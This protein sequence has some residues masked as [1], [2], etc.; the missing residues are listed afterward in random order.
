MFVH[1]LSRLVGKNEV[2]EIENGG[3]LTYVLN[4]LMPTPDRTSEDQFH[5]CVLFSIA[6]KHPVPVVNSI[7]INTTGTSSN[8]LLSHQSM[9]HCRARQISPPCPAVL[10]SCYCYYYGKSW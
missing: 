4:L 7:L 5:S 1:E 10:A 9:F 2:S 3:H 6:Q 8:T